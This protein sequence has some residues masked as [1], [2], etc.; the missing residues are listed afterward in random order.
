MNKEFI[1]AKQFYQFELYEKYLL[2][3][4]EK[5]F[6]D[7]SIV[8][9]GLTTLWVITADN[10][11]FNLIFLPNVH[12]YL[13]QIQL[14]QYTFSFG[15]ISTE[16]DKMRSL[17]FLNKYNAISPAGLTLINDTGEILIKYIVPLSVFEALNKETFLE[18]SKIFY[19]NCKTFKEA[20]QA[21]QE[22]PDSLDRIISDLV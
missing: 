11:S 7:R 8:D 22:A 2:Q 3:N 16:E 10:L 17:S 6:I 19:L 1:E 18:I 9:G 15:F 4:Y 20:W 21:Y 14:L 12:Q 13:S 5:S